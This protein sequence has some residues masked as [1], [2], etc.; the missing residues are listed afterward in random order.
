MTSLDEFRQVCTSLEKFGQVWTSLVK[1][2]QT[3]LSHY[4]SFQPSADDK[5]SLGDKFGDKLGDK[6][7]DKFG[8]VKTSLD[9]YAQV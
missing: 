3:C 2:L 7:G 6:F 5:F 4:F 9:K 8:R 1:M